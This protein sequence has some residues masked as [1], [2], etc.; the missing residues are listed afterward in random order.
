MITLND[1]AHK[2]QT[3]QENNGPKMLIAILFIYLF[4]QKRLLFFEIE[5]QLLT[6][7]DLSNHTSL[8]G[9]E[10]CIMAIEWEIKNHCKSICAPKINLFAAHI[11]SSPSRCCRC[12]FGFFWDTQSLTWQQL[13]EATAGYLFTLYSHTV[14]YWCYKMCPKCVCV[15]VRQKWKTT[16]SNENKLFIFQHWSK[17]CSYCWLLKFLLLHRLSLSHAIQRD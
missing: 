9:S 15:C 6:L 17:Y 7:S 14:H 2:K 16:N 5:L 4:L 3:E 11:T 12:G 13:S 10:S 8:V 1:G